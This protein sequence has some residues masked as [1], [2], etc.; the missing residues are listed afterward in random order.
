MRVL[1]SMLTVCGYG[2][3]VHRELFAAPIFVLVLY[4]GQCSF[5]CAFEYGT[6]VSVNSCL[7]LC[8]DCISIN[9]IISSMGVL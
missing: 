1:S 3:E 8:S 2:I 5:A 6:F 7:G 4:I 9:S